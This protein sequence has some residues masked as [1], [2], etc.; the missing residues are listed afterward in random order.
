M[1]KTPISSFKNRQNVR[2]VLDPT[3]GI[4]GAE[5]GQQSVTQFIGNNHN[6]RVGHEIRVSESDVMSE[7]REPDQSLTKKKSYVS[8]RL[9]EFLRRD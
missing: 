6:G 4:T 2:E 3:G 8:F 5:Q 1:T 9:K 7:G